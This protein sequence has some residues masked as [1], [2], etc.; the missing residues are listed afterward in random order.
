MVHRTNCDAAGATDLM[1]HRQI[2]D[3]KGDVW[4]V[5]EVRPSR[6][7]TEANRE[8]WLAVQSTHEKR[9]LAPFPTAWNELDDRELATLLDLARPVGRPKRLIE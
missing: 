8:G 4:D 5:W 3:E 6:S 1:A 7:L 9:R 2:T